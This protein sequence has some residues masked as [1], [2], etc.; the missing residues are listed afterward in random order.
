MHQRY[1]AIVFRLIGLQPFNQRIH[2]WN[3]L[4]LGGFVLLGPAAELA[5]KIIARLTVIRQANGLQIHTVHGRQHPV[6]LR[7][8]F[9]THRIRRFALTHFRQPGTPQDAPFAELHHIKH[10]A[11]NIT[12]FAQV[13]HIGHRYIGVL[14]CGHNTKFAIHRMGGLEQF[15]RRLTTQHIGAGGGSDLEGGVGLTT[16]ELVRFDGAFEAVDMLL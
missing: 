2:G 1:L 16:L 15:A 13:Q 7:V 8:H 14:Q 11:D 10:G 4:Q 6:H 5:L 12:V 3:F 9:T